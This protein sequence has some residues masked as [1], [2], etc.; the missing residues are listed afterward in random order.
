M[1]YCYPMTGTPG[2]ALPENWDEI[3]GARGC[4]P[5][6]CAFRDHLAELVE[7]GVRH[8]HGISTQ[9]VEELSEARERLGL[10]YAL[11]SDENGTLAKA[12]RLPT[13]DVE[14]RTMLK[15]LTMVVRD[16]TV[17]KV[18]Y[19]VFPPDRNA[20]DVLDWLRANPA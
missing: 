19:P 15:R 12:L 6:S 3:P 1:L 18:F 7:V 5:Q 2:N 9:S 11:L 10:P 17:A 13:M 16:G 20:S 14:G 4:T 8:V